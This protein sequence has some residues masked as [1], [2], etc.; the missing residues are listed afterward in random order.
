M[1]RSTALLR[2]MVLAGFSSAGEY[3]HVLP[4]RRSGYVDGMF[5]LSMLAG[6]CRVAGDEELRGKACR[7]LSMLASC[8][9]P[10][11]NWAALPHDG[12]TPF[13]GGWW[14]LGA[15]SFAGPA[16]MAWA[17]LAPAEDPR[18]HARML[19]AVA[20][21]FGW[22]CRVV[23]GLRQ[24]VSSVML[25]HLLLERRP[26]SSMRF[27]AARNPLYAWQLGVPCEADD[28]PNTGPWPA[29]DWPGEE[30]DTSGEVYTPTCS[31]VARYLC[32]TPI[33]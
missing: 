28:Y 26:P 9:E 17:G 24:H 2:E 11:R 29:K 14:K 33:A 5:H 10:A 23:R 12:Y 27:L 22:L 18:P 7:W 31:L 16:A 20:L 25:A 13:P 1:S 8:G 21:P 3:S 15:Q 19:C 30:P 6:A 32:G 4:F